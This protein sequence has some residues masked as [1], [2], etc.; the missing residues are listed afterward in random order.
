MIVDVPEF[1]IARIAF[2]EN[3]QGILCTIVGHAQIE[4]H[5]NALNEN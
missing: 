2:L 3:I 5:L 4:S 1:G